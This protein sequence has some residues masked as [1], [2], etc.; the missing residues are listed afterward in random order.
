[1]SAAQLENLAK[2]WRPFSTLVCVPRT[3][4][5]F[6]RLVT[7]LDAVTDEVGEDESHPLASFMD[8]LGALVEDY[9]ANF[10]PELE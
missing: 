9:E 6:N 5:D 3:E 10:I 2:H 7:L 1:M 4:D 8:V